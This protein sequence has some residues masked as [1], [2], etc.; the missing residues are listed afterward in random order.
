MKDT[1]IQ[2]KFS[3]YRN[4]NLSQ[5]VFSFGYCQIFL[6]L[7][8]SLLFEMYFLGFIPFFVLYFWHGIY[9]FDTVFL[10]CHCISVKLHSSYPII[11]E[12]FF[13]VYIKLK[14]LHNNKL[15]LFVI[16]TLRRIS[17]EKKGNPD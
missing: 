12:K 11:I 8:L 10:F 14:K 13:H 3:T 15:Q 2:L 4:Q 9:F 17:I 16:C 6:F 5:N 1:T 7:A